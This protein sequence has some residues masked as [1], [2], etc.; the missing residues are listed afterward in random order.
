MQNNIE[1]LIYN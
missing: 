1:W